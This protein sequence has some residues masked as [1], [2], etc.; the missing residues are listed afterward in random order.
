MTSLESIELYEAKRVT[1]A[2]LAFL[3]GLPR[4]RE[5]SLSGLSNITLQ[6]TAVFPARVRVDYNV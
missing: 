3:T 4:L 6:G 1:D 5:I 2:G